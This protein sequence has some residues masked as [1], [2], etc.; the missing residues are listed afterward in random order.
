LSSLSQNDKQTAVCIKR[1]YTDPISEDESR[2]KEM[3]K[4]VA[5]GLNPWD[6][7]RF[8]G[9][10]VVNRNLGGG[11]STPTTHGKLG[12]IPHEEE[13]CSEFSLSVPFA[14]I[15]LRRVFRFEEDDC[16][17]RLVL[18]SVRPHAIAQLPLDGFALNLI[19]LLLFE[20]PLEKFKYY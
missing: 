16:W 4:N 8:A 5:F 12:K 19:F 20:N 3:G 11:V 9:V 14:S 1:A 6:P 10:S 17:L 18:L 2:Q 13:F 7:V 15:V